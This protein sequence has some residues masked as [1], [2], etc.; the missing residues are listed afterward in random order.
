MWFSSG[1]IRIT[2]EYKMSALYILQ[3]TYIFPK[4]IFDWT[5]LLLFGND[6]FIRHSNFHGIQI[7][8][9]WKYKSRI[10]EIKSNGCFYYFFFV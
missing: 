6:D 1:K 8:V 7:R 3:F 9:D 2:P 5:L 4:N 10:L